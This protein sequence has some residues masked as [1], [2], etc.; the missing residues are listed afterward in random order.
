MSAGAMI[1]NSPQSPRAGV[2]IMVVSYWTSAG[3]RTRSSA[4][5]VHT[6]HC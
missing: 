6:L 4:S 3:P 1:G 2:T 5:T